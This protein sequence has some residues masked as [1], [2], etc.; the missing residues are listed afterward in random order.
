MTGTD[1]NTKKKKYKIQKYTN[2]YM[3]A[4]FLTGT[5]FFL[6]ANKHQLLQKVLTTHIILAIFNRH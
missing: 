5:Q 2:E 4:Y 1:A 3:G 6:L